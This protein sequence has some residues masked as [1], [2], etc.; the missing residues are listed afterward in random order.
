MTGDRRVSFI[1]GKLVWALL[2]P[3]NLLLLLLVAGA[4]GLALQRAWARP[5][6]VASIAA[7]AAVVLLPIG[8]MLTIP[9]EER[10]PPPQTQPGR[11]DGFVVLGGGVRTELSDLRGQP[12]FEQTM[13][14]FAT[15]PALA[16]RYPEA[17]LVFTGGPSYIEGSTT[18]EADVVGRFLDDHGVPPG[19]VILEN[20]ARS[21]RENATYALA[22]ARPQPGERWALVTSAKHMPRSMGVFRQAGWPPMVAWPV[23]YRTTGRLGLAL[24]L[25]TADRL[26]E[27]DEAAYEWFGLLYYRLLGYT[28]AVFPAP[29]R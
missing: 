7:L 2:K 19:R 5:L 16:W 18:T 28:D 8:T 14:R 21:T 25:Q 1:F 4:V 3:S 12:A 20:R 29:D 24:T 15:L 10:F 11:I 9:L 27:L 22:L 26:L 17:K 6:M 13:E 23:D